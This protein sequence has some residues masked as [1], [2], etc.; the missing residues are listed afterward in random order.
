MKRLLLGFSALFL[1]L[2]TTLVQARTQLPGQVSSVDQISH[3]NEIGY[4]TGT[5]IKE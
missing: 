3:T 2:F 4:G 5:T 1:G